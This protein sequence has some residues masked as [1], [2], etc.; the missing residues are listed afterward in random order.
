M[1]RNYVPRRLGCQ[2]LGEGLAITLRF[3]QAEYH[4]KLPATQA[5]IAR[6]FVTGLPMRQARGASAGLATG[7]IEPFST[8][9]RPRS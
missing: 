2:H 7:R 1:P 3:F 9:A 5:V 8:L 6:E 4:I